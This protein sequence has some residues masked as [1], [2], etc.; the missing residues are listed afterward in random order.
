MA[1]CLLET[2]MST[3]IVCV[4]CHGSVPAE[5]VEFL[6]DTGRPITCLSCSSERAKTVLLEYGHKTAGGAV[7]VGTDAE[8]IRLARRAY[9]RA[10]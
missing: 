2:P 8:Q 9:R 3:P 10:R 7:V 1:C 5:R 6:Q 4:R